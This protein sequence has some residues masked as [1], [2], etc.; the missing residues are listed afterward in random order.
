[1]HKLAL[2]QMVAGLG[3]IINDIKNKKRNKKSVVTMSFDAGKEDPDAR[4]QNDVKDRIKTLMDMDVPVFCLAGNLAKKGHPQVDT[5]PGIWASEDYPLLVI[6][7]VN[8]DG[9]VSIFSQGGDQVFLHAPGSGITCMPKSGNVPM[10]NKFGTSLACP[11]VAGEV[12]NLL[13]YDQSPFDTTDGQ[14]VKN[15]WNYMKTGAGSWARVDQGSRVI[16]NGVTEKDNPKVQPPPAPAPV[17]PIATSNPPQ[18]T[19]AAPPQCAGLAN[20]KYVAPDDLKDRIEKDF[21]P[22]AV[23]QGALD[24][25][26]G[27]L[28]RTYN[29]RTP[30]SVVISMEWAPGLNF[31]PNLDD[32]KKY[33]HAISDGCDGNDPHNPANYKAGGSMKVGDVTYH[34]L[35]LSLRQPAS[36]GLKGSCTCEYKLLYDECEIW[37]HGFS[38]AD[39]GENLKGNLGGCAILPKT[40]DFEYGLGDDGREWTAKF[41]TGVFQNHCVGDATASNG[42]PPH[43]DCGGSG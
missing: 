22:A 5:I 29:E 30:E 3:V 16:W 6:G 18:A 21:C 24:T 8:F 35:P 43:F 20:K 10:T 25:G 42:A 23:K 38:S 15:L 19:T 26:S 2:S 9:R 39:H 14:L 37:G 17:A 11:V 28:G 4:L 7:S 40:W 36:D 31:K 27:S 34:I 1:M 32:C 13:S 41:R 33:L 12:A